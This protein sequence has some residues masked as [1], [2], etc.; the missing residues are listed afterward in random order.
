MHSAGLYSICHAQR[1]SN[2]NTVQNTFRD[3]TARRRRRFSL[4]WWV[5]WRQ[6][7]VN[8]TVGQPYT[9]QGTRHCFGCSRMRSNAF[10]R[11]AS[12][13]KTNP[14]N[15]DR[16]HLQ[17]CYTNLWSGKSLSLATTRASAHGKANTWPN[18]NTQFVI[19]PKTGSCTDS[20]PLI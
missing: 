20:K 2:S 10:V 16:E 4:V 3:L 18:P 11:S 8:V 19:H 6:D 1:G 15:K 12:A 17:G 14:G 13:H 9:V 5:K 7:L